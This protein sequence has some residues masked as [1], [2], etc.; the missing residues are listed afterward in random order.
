MPQQRGLRGPLHAKTPAKLRI[1]RDQN[2]RQMILASSLRTSA[3]PANDA[4]ASNSEVSL[5]GDS[6]GHFEHAIANSLPRLGFSLCGHRCVLHRNTY[7]PCGHGLERGPLHQGRLF[8]GALHSR[9]LL[10]GQHSAAESRSAH[11]AGT[12]HAKT[13]AEFPNLTWPEFLSDDLGKLIAHARTPG[14][15][16]RGEQ[17]RDRLA[18]D[19]GRATLNMQSRTAHPGW[20]QAGPRS[21]TGALT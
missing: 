8:I 13:L 18:R 5:L 14:Q 7:L 15:R 20:I 12:L 2:F 19:G 10:R 9:Y 16:C 17:L 11:V 1:S 21:C 3:R 6:R 4:G